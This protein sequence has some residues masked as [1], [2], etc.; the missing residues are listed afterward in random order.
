M[1]TLLLIGFSAA[2]TVL[3]AGQSSREEGV[4]AIE[5]RLLDVPSASYKLRASYSGR[6]YEF[7]NTSSARVVKFRLGCAKRKDGQLKILSE[8]KLQETNL[9]PSGEKNSC[10]LWGSNHGFFPGEAC[11]KG[12]LAVIEVVLADGALWKLK[13]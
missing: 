6:G 5:S 8:R 3:F 10:Q 13:P 12:K 4:K 9:A 2:F 7:C 1:K 11:E